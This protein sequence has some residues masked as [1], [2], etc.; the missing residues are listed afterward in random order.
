M[1][2]L[3]AASMNEALAFLS[4]SQGCARIIA[5]ATDLYL[6]GMPERALDI[7]GIPETRSIEEKEGFII[8]GSAVTH[9]EAAASTL[10]QEKALALAEACS[11]VGSPQIRNLGTLGGNVITAAPAADA[12]VALVALGA[13][14]VFAGIRGDTGELEVEKLYE[15]FNR[16]RVDCS[17]KIMV[18]LIFKACGE[19][20]GSAFERF[21]SRRAL[22]LPIV[23]AAARVKISNG[24]FQDVRLVLAPVKPAPTRLLEVEAMLKGAS[25]AEDTY[26]R[27]EKTAVSEVEVRSS[28][29]RCT[30]Q[31]RSHLVGVL[32]ARVIRRAAKVALDRKRGA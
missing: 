16:T 31:Y 8:L 18:R 26:T 30:A 2:Y 29:L 17:R 24:V 6:K 5:G 12:A 19:N 25:V 11:L 20:E 28:L 23:N 9:S 15:S 13:K 14:A 21:A 22:A 7:T 27:I 3:K 10:V 4:D 1:S 32:A